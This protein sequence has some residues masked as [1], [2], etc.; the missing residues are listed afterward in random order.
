M[1][2]IFEKIKKL[3]SYKNGDFSKA[4]FDSCSSLKPKKQTYLDF[5]NSLKEKDGEEIALYMD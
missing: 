3:S 5:F 4:I 2:G 1:K